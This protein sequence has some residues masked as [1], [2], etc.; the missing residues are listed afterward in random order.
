M[1]MRKIVFLLL[2]ISNVLMASTCFAGAFAKT[3]GLPAIAMGEVACYGEQS[4]KAQYLKNFEELLLDRLQ[5]SDKVAVDYVS[6]SPA[7]SALLSEVHMNAIVNSKYFV[8]EQAKIALVRYYRSLDYTPTAKSDVFKLDS[9]TRVKLSNINELTD[10][11]YILF[12]NMR[13][14]EV[15][16]RHHGSTYNSS[17][18]GT[19]VK[20]DIDYYLVD[21]KSGTVYSG[22]SSADKGTQVYNLL[23]V[24]YGK[25]FTAE[26]LLQTVLETLTERIADDITQKGIKK[27]K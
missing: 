7:S 5:S 23:V 4:L 13:N 21:K 26:Q 16:V 25:Q 6:F 22:T 20:V 9:A 14:A 2:V 18:S 10:T 15:D 24:R 8:R 19:K 27:F 1:K 3:A 12:C 11:R 17:L